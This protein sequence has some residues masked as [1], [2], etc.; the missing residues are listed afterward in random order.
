[1]NHLTDLNK[2]LKELK[3]Y[4][5]GSRKIQIARELTKKFEQAYN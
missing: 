3:K 4:C 2:L 1:M 5:G